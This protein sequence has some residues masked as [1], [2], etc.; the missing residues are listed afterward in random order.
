[1]KSTIHSIRTTLKN[2][3]VISTEHDGSFDLKA[4]SNLV[5]VFAEG[6]NYKEDYKLEI[7]FDGELYIPTESQRE[8]FETIIYYQVKEKI[9][10]DTSQPFT[11]SELVNQVNLIHS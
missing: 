7:W 2:E 9:D 5:Q 1:M 10:N 3:S 6:V 4:V 8:E 11:T